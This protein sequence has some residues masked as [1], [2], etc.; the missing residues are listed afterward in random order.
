[1]IRHVV[2]L[3]I[4]SVAA[5]GTARSQ[6]HAIGIQGGATYTL[7]ESIQTTADPCDDFDQASPIG[8]EY[9]VAYRCT[10]DSMDVYA[11]GIMASACFRQ[12]SNHYY[13]G[14]SYLPR[15]DSDGE[16]VTDTIVFRTD[17]VSHRIDVRATLVF[18]TEFGLG[19]QTGFLVEHRTHTLSAGSVWV[20]GNGDLSY[21]ESLGYTVLCGGR[22][23]N[24]GSFTENSTDIWD[25]GITAG[26]YW[27]FDLNPLIVEPYASYA[28]SLS[29]N[30]SASAPK[31][32]LRLS[33]GLRLLLT[34]A[35]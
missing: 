21:L 1:M 4:V 31:P 24:G 16:A 30:Y 6:Y 14:R 7:F 10:F 11:F 28:T 23:V 20:E 35:H 34:L 17:L 2:H 19:L 27:R 29:D 18:E 3:V 5:V 22:G 12:E 26:A 8:Y 32:D 33:F 13:A 15:L 9:G 25:L